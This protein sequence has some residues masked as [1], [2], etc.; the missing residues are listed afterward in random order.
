[1]KWEPIA[2]MLLVLGLG[3]WLVSGPGRHTGL[4]DTRANAVLHDLRIGPSRGVVEHVAEA[5]GTHTY[6]LLLRNGAATD[7]LSEQEF[8]ELLGG[9]TAQRLRD[10]GANPLFRLFNI[11]T[12]ASL[13]WVAIGLGGQVAFFGRMA[14]QWLASER[15]RESYV[16]PAFWYLSLAGGVMLFTY[17]V[18]RQ[19]FV[20]VLG[21][22][23]GIVIYARNIRLIY[24]QRRRERHDADRAAERAAKEESRDRLAESGS[25]EAV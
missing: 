7:V 6:R 9:Q 12:W 16:P 19:D 8:T 13:A 22:C 23:T 2:A 20:G 25:R 17:F 15:K 21:Q 14:I 1:V 3:V 24:K 18:W 11:T 4:P 10:K 5:D